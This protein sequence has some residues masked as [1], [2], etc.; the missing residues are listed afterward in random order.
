M[1]KSVKTVI[2]IAILSF[3]ISAPISVIDDTP[4][5]WTDI[6]RPHKVAKAAKQ[7]IIDKSI[8]YHPYY[9]LRFL[10]LTESTILAN[11][12]KLPILSLLD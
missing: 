12:L 11:F 9:M 1:D 10:L 4:T 5:L 3:L 6:A 7:K 2:K 8:F